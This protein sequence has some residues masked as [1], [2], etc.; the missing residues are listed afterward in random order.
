MQQLLYME[1]IDKNFPGVRALKSVSLDIRP[2]AVHALLGEN[3]AGKSTLMKILSGAYKKDAGRIFWQGQ[4]FRS[5]RDAVEAGVG[6]PGRV[7]RQGA[8]LVVGTGAGLLRLVEVQPAG[9]RAMA[10]EE[11]VRGAP[12]FVGSLLGG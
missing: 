8:A 3:G 6:E 4:R 9:K 7:L 12:A 1:G 5:H 2:G 11:F 10:V